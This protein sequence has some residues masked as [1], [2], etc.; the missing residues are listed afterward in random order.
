MK[1]L[2]IIYWSGT[3][4]T[5]EM[6]K[7]IEQGAINAGAKVNILTVDKATIEDFKNADVVA[8]GSPSMGVEVIEESEMEPFV[9]SIES[10]VSGK[11]LGLF[12]SYGWGTGEWMENWVERMNN[13]GADVLDDGLIINGMPEGADS[14]LCINYG[15]NLVK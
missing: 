2:A 14:D 11:K 1:N 7:L 5:E 10:L 9:E 8:L 15:K 13:C 12:G 4:N 3:G 6:A